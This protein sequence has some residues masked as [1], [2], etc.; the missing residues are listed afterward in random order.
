M[1]L[2]SHTSLT[3][4]LV[5]AG[6]V[7]TQA[8]VLGL[9]GLPPGLPSTTDPS[10]SSPGGPGTPSPSLVATTA[11][12]LAPRTL[13]VQGFVLA[14]G[15]APEPGPAP[16]PATGR[17]GTRRE[18]QRILERAGYIDGNIHWFH[19]RRTNSRG[20]ALH[21]GVRGWTPS[22]SRFDSGLRALAWGYTYR[23][24][25]RTPALDATTWGWLRHT[26]RNYEAARRALRANPVISPG[27]T[28]RLFDAIV[29]RKVGRLT[30]VP[31]AGR[32]P[33][34][35]ALMTKE[36]GKVHWRNFRPT[37]SYAGAVGFCQLMP[38]TAH[39]AGLGVNEFHP[40][41]NVEGGVVYLNSLISRGRAPL[42]SRLRE[43]LARYNGGANPP[44]ESYTHYADPILAE[45]RRLGA[46]F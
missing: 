45:A 18:A 37:V 32:L 41:G 33:L 16:A 17:I 46:R 1:T 24:P 31:A 19:S 26:Q 34:L 27:T 8:S 44:R 21:R 6:S 43:A 2:R 36:S 10:A 39:G 3:A 12:R 13:G 23:H 4:L 22:A 7:T 30:R 11:P 25:A 35:R 28:P 14:P 38:R 15:F 9:T 5:L 40:A 20:R 42:A 29:S